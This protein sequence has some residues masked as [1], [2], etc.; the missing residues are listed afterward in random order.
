MEYIPILVTAPVEFSEAYKI[1]NSVKEGDPTQKESLD[2][3]LKEYKEGVNSESFLH[4]LGQKFISIGVTEIFKYTNSIDLT[5]IGKLSKEQWEEL[6]TKNKD[7]LPK[8]LATSMTSYV[9]DNQLTK[10][11][12]LK[13]NTKEKEIKKHIK[14]M[15]RYITEG[16]LDVL[17]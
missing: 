1:L 16:L 3:T 10:T 11:L 12:S 4:E 2:S 5:S 14:P 6:A 15:A 17:E 9:K 8:Y 7:K 13:W